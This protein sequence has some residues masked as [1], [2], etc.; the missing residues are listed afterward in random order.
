[1]KRNDKAMPL[2]SL[3]QTPSTA[4]KHFPRKQDLINARMIGI[5]GL[6]CFYSF[7]I[8]RDG[9]TPVSY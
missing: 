5:N 2:Q 1:M 4:A 8:T 9:T 3:R 7:L 6:F